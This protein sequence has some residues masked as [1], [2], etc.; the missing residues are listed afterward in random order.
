MGWTSQILDVGPRRPRAAR[1]TFLASRHTTPFFGARCALKCAILG[2][3]FG[4]RPAGV[5][6][7]VFG[8]PKM[9]PVCGFCPQNGS[10]WGLE[11]PPKLM[12]WTPQTL[13]FGPRRSRAARTTNFGEPSQDPVFG[14]RCALKWT[15]LG[16]RFGSRPAGVPTGVFGRPKMH[17]VCGFCP[18]ND[19]VVG[20][21]KS[22]ENR[23]VDP[24]TFYFPSTPTSGTSDCVFSGRLVSCGFP[25]INFNGVFGSGG[26]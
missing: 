16:C 13:D 26:E 22:A 12:G 8:R 20:T 18:Q 7:G 14:A 19:S 5:P 17:P 15:I 23:G 1:S 9:H 10:V 21:P 6:T 4:S 24:T 11:N 2:R 25:L 3:R